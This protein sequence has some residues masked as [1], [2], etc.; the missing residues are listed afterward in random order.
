MLNIIIQGILSLFLVFIMAFIGYSVYNY[1]YVQKLTDMIIYSNKNAVS[2][3]PRPEHIAG[4]RSS[5]SWYQPCCC[6]H[7]VAARD[8][9]RGGVQ[10]PVLEPATL[11]GRG[12]A[13]RP[14]GHIGPRRCRCA[15]RP[16]PRCQSTHVLPVVLDS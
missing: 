7:R 2:S 16:D 9:R 14:A 4:R 15:C 13:R 6:L 3:G 8:E 10:L 12:D 5:P 11:S 1:E